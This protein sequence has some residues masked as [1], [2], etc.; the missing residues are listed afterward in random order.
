[1]YRGARLACSFASSS[2]SP[3]LSVGVSARTAQHIHS[4]A[5]KPNRGLLS[6]V[7][8]LLLEAC[9]GFKG[10]YIL[11]ICDVDNGVFEEARDERE[12]VRTANRRQGCLVATVECVAYKL[13]C[14]VLARAHRA[15]C[16][17]AFSCCRVC[18]A[19]AVHASHHQRLCY[20]SDVCDR[21]GII[22]G[23]APVS[24]SVSCCCCG[25]WLR[26]SCRPLR[27]VPGFCCT[28]AAWAAEGKP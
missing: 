19:V 16:M 18:A 27:C 1:M 15:A 21:H 23:Q 4:I 8:S 7:A 13:T 2:A 14:P 5:S 11:L 10:G 28:R 17:D 3:G 9:G 22:R 25:V 24:V 6:K 20:G 26:I 12:T